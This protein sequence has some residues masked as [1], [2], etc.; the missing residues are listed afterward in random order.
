MSTMH[1]CLEEMLTEAKAI[2]RAFHLLP[3][4]AKTGAA[5]MMPCNADFAVTAASRMTHSLYEI[6]SGS[7]A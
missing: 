3:V 5:T 6:P 2:A 7:P 1:D 4:A